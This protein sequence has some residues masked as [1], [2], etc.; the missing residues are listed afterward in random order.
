MSFRIAFAK[1]RGAVECMQ[2]LKPGSIDLPPSF[3]AGKLT[4]WAAPDLDLLCV[5][6]RGRD[7]VSLLQQGYVDAA[8]GS[9]ML[10]AEYANSAIVPAASLDIG[11]CRLSLITQ[12]LRP[13]GGL[14]K[15]GTRYPRV[16]RERLNGIPRD[17]EIIELHGCV[18]AGLF[19][20]VCDAITDVVETGMTLSNLAL[21][22]REVL[23]RANHE[24]WL[25]SKDR[26][27][28]I[29]TLRVLMPA[30]SWEA[31]ARAHITSAI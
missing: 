12:D 28:C 4:V 24:V 10:F 5:V 16:T 27:Q 1:G 31:E 8:I 17:T 3:N 9:N 21:V 14:R 25:R 15:I 6:V 30:V 22:E 19:L 7:L 20:N 13:K 29:E 26:D 2:L 11:V 23:H 18:E